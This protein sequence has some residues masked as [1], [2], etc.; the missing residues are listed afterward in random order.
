MVDINP[1]ISIIF[2]NINDLNVPRQR[3]SDEWNKQTKKQDPGVCCHF[4]YKY[5]YRL[6]IDGWRNIE[7]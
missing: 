3:L 1:A 5:I 6:N 2:F 7:I 4:K